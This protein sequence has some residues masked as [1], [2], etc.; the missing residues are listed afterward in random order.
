M[1]NVV[2]KFYK[3]LAK[4]T[5]GAVAISTTAKDAEEFIREVVVEM[6]I[7]LAAC[8]AASK[9]NTEFALS[10]I[11]SQ[12]CELWAKLRGYKADGVFERR[13]LISGEPTPESHMVLM[14]PISYDVALE[15]EGSQSLP[16]IVPGRSLQ[17]RISEDE[18]VLVHAVISGREDFRH[19]IGKL[20]SEDFLTHLVSWPTIEKIL[21]G[22]NIEITDIKDLAAAGEL[23][24]ALQV[25]AAGIELNHLHDAVQSLLNSWSLTQSVIESGRD[26][27]AALGTY[28]RRVKLAFSAYK[29]SL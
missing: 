21:D 28:K 9:A 8:G 2:V 25:P 10:Q 15:P 22:G 19:I 26:E 27:V 17:N 18:L 12:I 14:N 16:G 11:L 24:S 7:Y 13:L 5:N 6:P 3:D 20:R 29:R 23:A 1:R 4:G